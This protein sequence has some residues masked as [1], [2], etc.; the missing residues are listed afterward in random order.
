MARLYLAQGHL[1]AARRI[2]RELRGH[3]AGELQQELAAADERCTQ[4]LKELLA[5]VQQRR[6]RS[7]D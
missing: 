7:S 6:V 3:E 5:R 4:V 2:I 1:E